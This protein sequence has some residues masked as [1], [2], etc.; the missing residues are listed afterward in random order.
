MKILIGLFIYFS[1]LTCSVSWDF[2]SPD[3]HPDWMRTNLSSEI[4]R[5]KALIKANP[6]NLDSLAQLSELYLAKKQY[7]QANRY[8]DLAKLKGLNSPFYFLCRGRLLDATGKNSEAEN[9]LFKALLDSRQEFPEYFFYFANHLFY[10]G[11][12]HRAA[13]WLQLGLKLHPRNPQLLTLLGWTLLS[14]NNWQEAEVVLIKA[15]QHYPEM[16][17]HIS[18]NLAKMY[19]ILQNWDFTLYNLRRCA[20]KGYR[21][22]N[23]I[24][25]E[26]RFEPL[27]NHP[28]FKLLL[29]QSHE[30][31]LKFLNQN[32]FRKI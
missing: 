3:F 32:K 28:Q 12:H 17:S 23:N 19:A 6:S 30:N 15:R 14:S 9:Y 16:D 20:L 10:R 13:N 29:N 18:Y 2:K 8:L 21:N 4:T 27:R 25:M 7:S 1:L 11:L 5:W 22:Y 24:S 26:D 31:E